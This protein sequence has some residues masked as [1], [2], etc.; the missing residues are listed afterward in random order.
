MDAIWWVIWSTVI[1]GGVA[2]VIVWFLNKVIFK[3]KVRIT[4]L[5]NTNIELDFRAR[6]YNKGGV[7]YWRL[8]KERTKELRDMPVPP[9]GAINIAKRGKKSVE[10]IRTPTGEYIFLEKNIN[11]TKIPDL[12]KGMPKEILQMKD[13]TKQR[14]LIQKYQEIKLKQWKL[15]NKGI[16]LEGSYQPFTSK[17]RMIMVNNF[18]K[19]NARKGFSLKEHL[20]QMVA[21]GA[22]V[23]IVLG[24][25]IF[26][27]DIAKPAIEARRIGLQEQAIYQENLEILREIRLD[28]QTIKSEQESG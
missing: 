21:I 13:V 28:V 18:E 1:F 26:W 19:A 7:L 11:L 8:D 12:N 9:A 25:M 3:H 20:P 4:D 23:L 16:L 5:G 27:G 17:Q 24:L 14:A 2:W 10:A 6:N 22:L 15:E